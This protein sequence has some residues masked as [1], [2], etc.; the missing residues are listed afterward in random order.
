M[1]IQC[2]L[3][4]SCCFLDTNTVITRQLIRTARTLEEGWQVCG[5]EWVQEQRKTS[6]VLDASGLLDF[7]MLWPVLTWRAFWKLW[8]VYY[9]NFPNFFLRRGKV[10]IRGSASTSIFACSLYS[11]WPV[12]RLHFVGQTQGKLNRSAGL[13]KIL[14]NKG[15]EAAKHNDII[16]KFS[17]LGIKCF[18]RSK[19]ISVCT[20]K[21]Y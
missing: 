4:S 10:R 6:Q 11:S 15:K 18:G 14:N 9:F 13:N 7:T 12:Q 19:S 1:G 21:I 8:T 20:F 16:F 3:H 2:F 17:C 5:E